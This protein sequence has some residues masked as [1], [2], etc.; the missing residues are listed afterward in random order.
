[1]QV[2]RNAYFCTSRRS[3]R[4]RSGGLRDVFRIREI[5]KRKGLT[6]EAV[7]EAVGV[8]HSTFSRYERGQAWPSAEKLKAIAR[9]L[10]CSVAELFSDY[11][12]PTPGVA[13]FMTLTADLDEDRIRRILD[14][15]RLL[16]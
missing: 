13:E 15:F 7:A 11:E 12:A 1:M 14:A 8:D 5:R 2:A 16:K 6:Q 9:A 3:Y 4:R 10:D